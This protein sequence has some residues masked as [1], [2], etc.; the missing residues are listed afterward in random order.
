M[1]PQ[2]LLDLIGSSIPS[3]W[4]LEILI[5][6]HRGSARSWSAADINREVRG[7]ALVV[8]NAL[9]ALSAAGLVLEESPGA[10]RYSPARP[11]LA[12][13]VDRLTLAYAEMRFA[14]TQAI[15]AAP[16]AKIRTFADAFRLKKD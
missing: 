13:T 1:L 2:D 6:L 14:V 10:F 4:T 3:V 9:A 15:L 11:E 8:A 12:S 7:S 16:N 5:L